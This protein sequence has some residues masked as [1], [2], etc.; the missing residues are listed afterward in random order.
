MTLTSYTKTTDNVYVKTDEITIA[1]YA[2]V[3]TADQSLDA[4]VDALRAYVDRRGAKAVEFTDHAQSGCK[5][6]RPALDAMLDAVRRRE[7]DAVAITKLDRLARS[8]RHLCELAETFKALDVDLVVLDQGVDTSTPTG[9]LLFDVL[10]A[11]AE[12]EAGLIRERTRAGLAAAR[13]RGR[14]PGR[15]RAK[16]D[17]AL[18]ARVRR[19]R[20]AGRSLAQVADVLGIS[21]SLAAKLEREA[22][23]KAA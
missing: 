18:L 5:S 4:Q 7:V 12:F 22:R 19:L 11:V 1:T 23:A 13:R 17:P 10:A 14:R 16:R 3:S 15:P 6:R 21:K 2:R 20:S 9:K 8:T